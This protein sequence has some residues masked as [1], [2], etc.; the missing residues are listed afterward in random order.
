M[1]WSIYWWGV[2]IDSQNQEERELLKKVFELLEKKS[3]TLSH[4]DEASFNGNSLIFG[5]CG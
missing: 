3:E 1:K 5:E 2:S 4:T